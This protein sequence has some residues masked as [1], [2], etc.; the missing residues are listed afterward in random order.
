M[1]AG[2]W[3]DAYYPYYVP[4]VADYADIRECPSDPTDGRNL[5]QGSEND[6]DV[7]DRCR[8]PGLNGDAEYVWRSGPGGEKCYSYNP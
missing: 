7:D 2:W 4:Y 8:G 3:G 5:C 6:W 1:D